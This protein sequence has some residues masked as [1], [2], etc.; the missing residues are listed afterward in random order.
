MGS[1]RNQA[2]RVLVVKLG[3]F[4]DIVLADGA[5]RDIREHHCDAHI[6]LLTRKGFAPLLQRCPWV[7]TVVVDDNAPRWRID[8]MLALRQRLHAGYFDAAYDLQN[9]PRSRFYRRWLSAGSTTWSSEALPRA[10]ACSVPARHATQLRAAGITPHWSEQPAPGWIATDAGALLTQAGVEHPFVVLLP[11]SSARHPHKRWPH[12]AGLAS[13][14]VRGGLIV[15]S[16]P[17]IEEPGIATGFDG[18]VLKRDGQVLTLP[19]L[20]G[21]L[22]RAACVVGNDSGPTHL[23]ACLGTPTVA[24]F[25]TTSPARISTGIESRGAVCL[26]APVVAGI[27]IEHVFEAIQCQLDRA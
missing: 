25:E 7:D 21:V 6:T 20:A 4:G 24:L 23:A 13:R 15:A 11:G 27:G 26:D 18:F 17:G 10:V 19:E 14:L 3:A 8:H 12:Y 2:E 22:Q 1:S 5:L 9:S 16:I